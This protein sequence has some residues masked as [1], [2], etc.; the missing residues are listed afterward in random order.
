MKKVVSV[1]LLLITLSSAGVDL[2][3]FSPSS[4]IVRPEHAKHLLYFNKVAVDGYVTIGR[5]KLFASAPLAL[6]LDNGNDRTQFGIGDIEIYG[7]IPFALFEPRLGVITPGVYVTH[8]DRA[9]IGSQDF[10]IGVGGALKPHRYRS[11]GVL[12]SFE[13]ML[14]FYI[15]ND[16]GFGTPG[17]VDLFSLLKGSYFFKSGMKVNLETLINLGI[18]EWQWNAKGTK[19]V[20]CTIVPTLSFSMP[21]GSSLELGLKAGAGPTY[22]RTGARALKKSGTNISVG[23][24]FILTV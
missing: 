4:W 11:Q 16:P 8:A 7:G 15:A 1:L 12:F 24:Y 21:M 17:S 6:S 23:L 22:E 18:V 13:S 19:S 20:A 2:L 9:W 3:T 10:K 14:Y 5:V